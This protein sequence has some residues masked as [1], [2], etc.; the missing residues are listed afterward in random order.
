[1]LVQSVTS[2]KNKTSFEGINIFRDIYPSKKVGI[3]IFANAEKDLVQ[4]IEPNI[5]IERPVGSSKNAEILVDM[6]NTLGKKIMLPENL[7]KVRELL[8]K[9]VE[10]VKPELEKTHTWPNGKTYTVHEKTLAGIQKAI[11]E[12]TPEYFAKNGF[13]PSFETDASLCFKA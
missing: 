3:T 8:V 12:A 10:D 13:F 6:L 4:F 2:Q 11:N 7:T 1:M 9:S 5:G